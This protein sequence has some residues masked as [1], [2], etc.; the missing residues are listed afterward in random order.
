M[1]IMMSSCSR[2]WFSRHPA[3]TLHVPAMLIVFVV[4]RFFEWLETA[5]EE[6]E[7]DEE[8]DDEVMKGV[9]RPDNRSKLR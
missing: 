8:E 9:V 3:N 4:C 2:S 5:E 7:G 6:E 1:V